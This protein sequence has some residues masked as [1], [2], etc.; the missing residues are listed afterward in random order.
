MAIALIVAL[1]VTA[2]LYLR[3]WSHL[4]S[5]GVAVISGWR[6]ASFVIGLVFV[7]IALASPLA[8]YDEAL[9]SVHMIQHLL[10]MTIA[11]ALLLLGAPMMPLLHGIPDA[12]MR[13]VVSRVLR[14]RPLQR[15]GHAVTQPAFGLFAASAALIVW[16]VPA[17]F[18]LALRSEAVHVVEHASFLIAGFLFWWPVIEPWPSAVPWPRWSLVFYLFLATLPCD[19]LSGF[20]VFSERLVY[21]SYLTAARPWGISAVADQQFAG[22]L[23]WT[24][25]TI[26]YLVPGGILC[27]KLLS[28]R[29]LAQPAPPEFCGSVDSTGS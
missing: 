19:V 1:L 23:M 24:A 13:A 25:V 15:V 22:A 9:L 5:A 17:A 3:G 28:P 12:V 29:R 16:H 26:L 21:P 2:V 18:E 7:W 11:P 8:S 6:A 20:L 14:W 27:V 10:L 4:R